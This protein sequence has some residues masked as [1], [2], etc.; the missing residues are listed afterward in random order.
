MTIEIY[1]LNFL[2][3]VLVY[4]C[5]NGIATSYLLSEFRRGHQI[6]SH[7]TRQRDQLRLPLAKTT[8]YHGS[9]GSMVHVPIIPCPLILDL[10]QT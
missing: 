6:H 10:Q 1:I 8:K 7:F 4:K 9:L 2:K 3:S 5:I